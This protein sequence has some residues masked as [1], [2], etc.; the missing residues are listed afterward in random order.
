LQLLRLERL[1]RLLF[2]RQQI[3]GAHRSGH[4]AAF[5]VRVH[6]WWLVTHATHRFLPP[7]PVATIRS[8]DASGGAVYN[9]AGGSQRWFKYGGAPTFTGTVH[10]SGSKAG[11]K[12]RGNANA[13]WGDG[14]FP[15]IDNTSNKGCAF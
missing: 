2:Y 13:D 6:A 11:Q 9:F 15:I 5:A 4:R 8:Q 3:E 12:S 14:R 7:T 10:F 1:Q